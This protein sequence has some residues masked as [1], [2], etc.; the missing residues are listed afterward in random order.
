V[1]KK[2]WIV[3]TAVVLIAGLGVV[4]YQRIAAQQATDG[5][6]TETAVVRRGT[7]LVTADATGSLAPQ[8]EVSLSFSSGGRVDEVL[9][10]E[11]QMVETGQPLARLETDDL[12]LQ[13]A[14]AEV[15]LAAA[16]AQLAQLLAPPQPE[17]IAVY[18]ANLQAMQAQVSAAAANR[19]QVTA[20]PDAAQI[21]DA[22][23]Q[24][25]SAQAQYKT[26]RD[27]HDRTMICKTFTLPKGFT[28]PDGTKPDD[29]EVTICPGLGPPE[30]QTRYNMEAAE[31]ALAAAQ[32]QLNE[33]LDG[34]DADE[35][36]AAQANV[37]T[38][39]AQR[40]ATQAE[41]DL[42]LAGPMEEQIQTTQAA[43][44][45]ARAA[46][47]QARL[48]LE[49]G[50]L[51]APTA[52]TVTFLGVQPGEIVSANQPVIVLSNLAAP[53]ID[54]NLDETDVSRVAVGQEVQV[55]LDAFP[56]VEMTGEVTYI[57]PVAQTETGVVLYPVTVRL[58]P[59]DLPVRTGMT[60]DVSI[61][62]VSQEDTLIVPLRAVKTEGEH[63]YVDRLADGQI[64]RVEVELG[65]MTDTEI[66]IT[67]GL[68]EGDVVIVVE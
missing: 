5:E 9:V 29:T 67:S 65:L 17:E 60:A 33:L 1:N 44:D 19:D 64:K 40:N 20:G 4:G 58:R 23:A 3:G 36:R 48:R 56:G 55:S 28:M 2:R 66:E 68:A 62:T 57:A 8:A 63:A 16:E 24:V 26:A 45:E 54:V 12:E 41:L 14:Q 32:A 34:T 18:E 61:V 46:L 53:E 35:I 13:V 31:A 39:A 59:T 50:T 51:T 47:D 42:L 22:E 7:L 15:G 27:T 11:G 21:A 49:K 43:V 25:A 10:E 52:G 38:V 30:E 6:P 37:L